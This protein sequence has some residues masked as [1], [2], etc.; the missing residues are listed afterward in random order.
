MSEQV[1]D[2][3]LKHKLVAILRGLDAEQAIPVA[4]ALYAGGIRLLEIPFNQQKANEA[5]SIIALLSQHFGEKL[6]IGAGTALTQ[7]QVD[8]ASDAGAA[9]ILSPS[10]SAAVIERTK[11]RGMVSIPGAATPSE[12]VAAYAYGADIVKWFPAGDLGISYM[13]SI[14]TPLSHIPVMAVGGID[15]SNLQEWLEAGVSSVGVG[16]RLVQEQWVK[17]GQY[18]A[19]ADLARKYV[20][21]I[22]QMQQEE[23]R[24]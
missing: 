3:I 14:R 2:I 17:E 8:L 21:V 24:P 11:A 1:M 23:K 6:C 7:E 16:A 4:E 5:S 22:S 9:F 20:S 12:M 19:L 13:K 18:E 15:V 10:T